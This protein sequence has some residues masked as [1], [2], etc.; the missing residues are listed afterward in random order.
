MSMKEKSNEGKMKVDMKN[1][2]F[3]IYE[4]KRI[5]IRRE[6]KAEF[7]W[8]RIWTGKNREW[9]TNDNEKVVKERESKKQ[10]HD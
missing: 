6:L 5:Q 10:K 1:K 4:K 8:E 2:E 7:I 9:R 3:R